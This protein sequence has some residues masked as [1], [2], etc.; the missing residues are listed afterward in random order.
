MIQRL[1]IQNY[2]ALRDVTLDLT[3]IHVLI[4]PNDSGKTSILEAAAALCR[5]VDYPLPEAFLGS[6][7]GRE[8]VWSGNPA[9]SVCIG[10]DLVD[11][12]RELRYRMCV[13]FDEDGR[14]AWP[15]GEE[16]S[17]AGGPSVQSSGDRH[18]RSQLLR[19]VRYAE[20]HPEASEGPY[21]LVHRALST[22]DYCRWNPR[23]MALPNAPDVARKFQ[24]EI[25]GFGLPL[26][27]DELL[28][29]SRTR[30]DELEREFRAVFPNVQ[31]IQ[32]RQQ[33]AFKAKTGSTTYVLDL[34]H[35][36]GKGLYFQLAS[37]TEPIPASQV[38]DGML[39]V[40][41]FLVL[42]YVP[43]KCRLILIEEPE[44]CVYPKL[45]KGVVD[46]LR[47]LVGNHQ[48]T[49]ILLTTHS[50]YLMDLFRPEE[51]TLCRK[52]DDGSVSVHPLSKSKTVQE[53]ID[54]FT[55]GEIWTAEG[56]DKLAGL[57]TESGDAKP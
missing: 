22:A 18:S 48:E 55:L 19:A 11:R 6:W 1:R 45:L 7:S 56:D 26:V 8:L 29:L 31:H 27:L 37:S 43:R 28:S 10:A 51:V 54:L 21:P 33:P 32:Q 30:F 35:A 15:A 9:D 14:V 44:N 23:V 38:S 24:I 41:G 13:A 4:G 40:L 2:K 46:I 57:A 12:G 42:L 17:V 36:D 39:L 5:S 34:T 53:Q 20:E 52:E 49:Q 3:P 50:P 47:K 16:A 25:S